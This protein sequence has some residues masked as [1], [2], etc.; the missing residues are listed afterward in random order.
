MS[1][2][3]IQAIGQYLTFSIENE[4]YAIDVSKVKE[5]L[6]L[7]PITK[8]PKTPPFMRGVINLR[9]GVVPV[10]DMRLKFGLP[11]VEPTV[12]TSIIVLEVK[13]NDETIVLGAITD[14]VQEVIELLS[15]NIEPPPRIGTKLNTD[16]IHGMGKHNEQFLII[17]NI[18]KVF[19]SEEL[20]PTLV[21][22][23]ET[24]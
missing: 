22:Q 20:V 2:N 1:D 24:E 5:V 11:A 12:D 17:L 21:E 18:D 8:V 4:K 13:V 23:G 9:G 14:S 3:I 7:V 6:E 19:T 16:F 10:I 15:E